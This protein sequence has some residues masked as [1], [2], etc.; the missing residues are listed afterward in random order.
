MEFRIG[1]FG[2]WVQ[3]LCFRAHF[4]FGHNKIPSTLRIIFFG[5]D[6][7]AGEF[8]LKK[9]ALGH[10]ISYA[11][12]DGFCWEILDTRTNWWLL[13]S[14]RPTCR[15]KMHSVT[16]ASLLWASTVPSTKR[17]NKTT[18]ICYGKDYMRLHTWNFVLYALNID[19]SLL[20]HL[21]VITFKRHGL[22]QLK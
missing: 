12:E 3:E 14:V 8:V 7:V 9:K 13:V 18:P 10:H 4:L 21:K 20:R 22:S 6:K 1:K 5:Q 2:L 17:D 11:K 16:M 19:I 15:L